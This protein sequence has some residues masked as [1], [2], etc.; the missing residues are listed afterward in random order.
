MLHRGVAVS[1]CRSVRPCNKVLWLSLRYKTSWTGILT[2]VK[3][4]IPKVNELLK[5]K[6]N[7]KIIKFC[8]ELV[9]FHWVQ[10]SN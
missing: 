10:G 5:Y 8:E 1:I 3:K 7:F 2:V 9:K 4:Y 6:F